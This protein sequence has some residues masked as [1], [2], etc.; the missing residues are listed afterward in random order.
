M[1]TARM[2]LPN[3]PHPF[4]LDTGLGPGVLVDIAILTLFAES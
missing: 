1:K 2:M 4:A 3:F